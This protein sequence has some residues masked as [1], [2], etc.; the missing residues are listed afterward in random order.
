MK[1]VAPPPL[2]R[3]FSNLFTRDMSTQFDPLD[4][5]FLKILAEVAS[6]KNK[7]D[8]LRSNINRWI[9]SMEIMFAKQGIVNTERP[10]VAAKNIEGEF[11]TELYSIVEK[12]EA[13][14]GPIGWDQFKNFMIAFNGKYC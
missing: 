13:D 5:Y 4:S 11:G 8:P 2:P 14:F 12:A 7:Y 3:T 6:D 9:C 10:L 1:G